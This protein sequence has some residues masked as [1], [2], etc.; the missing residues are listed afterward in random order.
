MGHFKMSR[1]EMLHL[2]TAIFQMV[3]IVAS[4][5]SVF[6]CQRKV[7]FSNI[8]LPLAQIFILTYSNWVKALEVT[9]WRALLNYD[10]LFP[11]SVS[12]LKNF[13]LHLS[14]EKELTIYHPLLPAPAQHT[15]IR[16]DK[17]FAFQFNLKMSGYQICSSKTLKFVP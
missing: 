12:M 2:H 4:G 8:T 6:W 17:L 3:I 16:F 1:F 10:F 14:L 13:Q 9:N 15:V 5:L 11:V 7:L